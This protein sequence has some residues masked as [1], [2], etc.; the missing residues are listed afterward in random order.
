MARGAAAALITLALLTAV[1]LPLAACAGDRPRVFAYARLAA[2]GLGSL[3]CH[4]KPDRSFVSCARQWPVCAR[5]TGLYLGAALGALAGLGGVGRG[6]SW[7]R[8]RRGVLVAAL[9]T[10]VLWSVEMAGWW[11]PGSPM[12]AAVS[13]LLGTTGG[14]WLA[15]VA[16]GD[17]R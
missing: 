1:A 5:C 9:P 7:R 15:A 12:R 8:W 2:Y 14:A 4:Q 16:R 3:V 11:D 10:A 6:A 17:L 13:A